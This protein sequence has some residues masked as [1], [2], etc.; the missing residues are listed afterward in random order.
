M[1]K[2][3]DNIWRNNRFSTW[4]PNVWDFIAMLLV[5]AVFTLFAWG[6]KQ[7]SVPY[8][9]GQ[10][11]PIHLEASYLPSYALNTVLRMLIA[12]LISLLFTF[13][14]ATLAA[15]NKHAERV[16]IPLIDILQ[17]VPVYG[18]LSLTIT[19]FI[20]LFPGSMWGPECAV[21][22]MLFTA[23]VWNM[24]LGFYQSLKTIPKNLDE[25]ASIFQLSAWQRFWRLEVPFAMPSLIWNFMLSMSASWF[26]IVGTEAITVNN[27]TILLPGIGS[28][29]AV[30]NNQ[31]DKAAIFYAIAVM[32][33]VIV[34]YDQLLCRPIVCW[35]DKF[36]AELTAGEHAPKSWVVTLL[37]KTRLLFYLGEFFSLLLDAIVNFKLIHSESVGRLQKPIKKNTKIALISA[38]Y[39]LIFIIC[40]LGIFS[41]LHFIFQ[42]LSLKE[43]GHVFVLGL[44]TTMR[45]FILIVVS[46][47]I[48][49]PVGVW[50]G[51]RPNVARYAQP[52]VQI[53]AA[54][55]ANLFFPIFVIFILAYHL[56]P[57]I[58]LTPLI[59]L[60]AQWY[61]L[62][63]VIAGASA[64]PEDIHAVT[65]SFGV[66][67]W[68]W[69]WR[70]IL[71]GI[72]PFYITGAITSCGGA[73]NASVLAEVVHWGNST[74]VAQGLGSYITQY[75]TTGDFPRVALGIVIMCIYVLV[76]NRIIWQP[77]YNLAQRRFL[78]D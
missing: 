14:F 31:M 74:L 11:I 42:D 67:G 34:L 8:H 49:I 56:N 3:I 78:M 58:W 18:Y 66:T 57:D 61:I 48:W 27:Q 76:F 77:L 4:R 54:F 2:N 5:F 73:W 17:S 68:L 9:I 7:M 59:I 29:L 47:L 45:L 43:A 25:A 37:L 63:N 55:P 13:V 1:P 36:K 70:I 35:A 62:F 12:M 16:I 72:F 15:K 41:L 19:A 39:A 33:I 6:G 22:F 44:Y 20:A 30:A 10:A 65:R 69:W 32:L 52:I 51:M 40:A 71:P 60:G 50:I 38:W 24:A 21:I 26:F 53:L 46:S 64:I 28:Y 75:T 23:Q